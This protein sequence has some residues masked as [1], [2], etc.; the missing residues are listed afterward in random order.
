MRRGFWKTREGQQVRIR[1][2]DDR[3]LLNTLR[4][5]QRHAWRRLVAANLAYIDG[6]RPTAD[7]AE[8]AFEA[9]ADHVAELTTEDALEDMPKYQE[10]AE[11]ARRRGL[12]IP[13]PPVVATAV[14]GLMA[15]H[16]GRPLS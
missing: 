4:M 9:E 15:E 10:L 3:H 13:R 7:M 16:Q 14:L 6:P 11:E 5:L 12:D 8:M 1:D 2:M